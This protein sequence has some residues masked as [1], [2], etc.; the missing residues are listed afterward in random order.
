MPVLEQLTQVLTSL[1]HVLQA[2]YVPLGT[3]SGTGQASAGAAQM[4]AGGSGGCA[5]AGASG[6]GCGAQMQAA[7]AGMQP[8]GGAFGGPLAQST[9]GSMSPAPAGPLVSGSQ[10]HSKKD[11]ALVVADVARKLGVDPVLAVATMLVESNGDNTN[12][13]GDNGTSFGL[14]Q[15]HMGGHLP[16]DWYPG[17][18]GHV[19]VFDPR[20]NAEIALQRFASNQGRFSGPELA[21]QSQR[22]ANPAKYKAAVANRMAEA[23][24]L[25]GM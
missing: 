22:P 19:N 20:K 4:Q 6:A 17:K 7:A 25:L 21:Y 2:M 5:M 23:R 12:N 11:N 9:V 24:S 18:P 15:L 16:K 1:I 10:R 13:T 3:A 8:T 14:F